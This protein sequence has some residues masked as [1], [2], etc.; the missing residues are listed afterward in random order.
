[1]IYSTYVNLTGAR[2]IQLDSSHVEYIFAML[3]MPFEELFDEAEEHALTCLE[4]VWTLIITTDKEEL[5]K[6]TVDYQEKGTE[7]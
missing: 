1:M 6:V 3:E 2:C 4:G 7:F 5:E